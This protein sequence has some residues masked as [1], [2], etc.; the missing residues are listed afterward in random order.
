MGPKI[1]HT[2]YLFSRA[3]EGVKKTKSTRY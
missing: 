3:V 1:A 2:K